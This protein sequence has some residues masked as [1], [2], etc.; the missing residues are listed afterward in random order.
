M[1][2]NIQTSYLVCAVTLFVIAGCSREDSGTPTTDDQGNVYQSAIA[3]PRRPAEDLSRDAGR[4]PAENLEF[5]G[6]VPGQR[7]LD[8]SSG[9]GYFTRIISEV[10]GSNGSVVANNSGSRI[11]DEFKANLQEQLSSYDNIE[12]NYET[13]ETISLPDNSVDT[14]LLSLI[15]HHWHYA[16]EWGEF[17]PAISLQRYDN[18]FR[19]LKPGGV[20]AVIDHEAQAGMTRK[21][22]DDIHRIPGATAIADITLAGFVIDPET[23]ISNIHANQPNDDTTTRWPDEPRDMTQRIVHRFRKPMN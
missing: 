10:V 15:V 12:L 2:L 14:V 11:N 7:V 22:S 20:F 8:I 18:I 1:K 3:D 6:I 23:D 16:E 9:T 4:K 21:D 5:F 19:M 17:V 13:P